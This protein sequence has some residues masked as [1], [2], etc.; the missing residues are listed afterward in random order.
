M[1]SGQGREGKQGS[2]AP[3]IW[4]SKMVAWRYRMSEKWVVRCDK[5]RELAFKERGCLFWTTAA[6]EKFESH[7]M[8]EPKGFEITSFIR[9]SVP[10]MHLQVR[11]RKPFKLR[12]DIL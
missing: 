9:H 4:N 11:T 6:L 10:P 2:D 8:N 5:L 3:L 1:V 7:R 12:M